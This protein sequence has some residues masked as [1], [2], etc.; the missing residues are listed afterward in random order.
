[1]TPSSKFSMLFTSKLW[2]IF[3]GIHE[4]FSILALFKKHFSI[5]TGR[6]VFCYA[7]CR[8]EWSKAFKNYSRNDECIMHVIHSATTVI[9]R[10]VS[11][12]CSRSY[13]IEIKDFGNFK[14]IFYILNVPKKLYIL[15]V[16]KNFLF[17]TL[18][19]VYYLLLIWLLTQII[20]TENS[21]IFK[22]FTKVTLLSHAFYFSILFFC[23]E[24]IQWKSPHVPGR[25]DGTFAPSRRQVPYLVR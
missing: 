17:L 9:N 19:K 23:V 22:S 14:K 18:K 25:D 15:N 24:C 6:G 1:M 10:V 7:I 4:N 2:L 13:L 3:D 11:E 8:T 5:L 21:K 16:P 20:N 12:W